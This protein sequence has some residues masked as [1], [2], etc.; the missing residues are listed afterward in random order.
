MPAGRVELDRSVIAGTIHGEGQLGARAEADPDQDR[1]AANGAIFDIALVPGGTVD[2][3]EQQAAAPGT[4][5]LIVLYRVH[6]R[7]HPRE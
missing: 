1:L 6:G 7:F 4:L 5:G 2:L 3:Q